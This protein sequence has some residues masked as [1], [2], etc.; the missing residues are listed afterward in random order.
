MSSRARFQNREMRALNHEHIFLHS[1]RLHV[2]E[3]A[4]R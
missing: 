3:D 2:A 1:I 4:H